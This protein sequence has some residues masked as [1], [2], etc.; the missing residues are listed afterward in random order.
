ML[1]ALTR[2]AALAAGRAERGAA[3]P[4]RHRARRR[5]AVRLILRGPS[6]ACDRQEGEQDHGARPRSDGRH[7]RRLASRLRTGHVRGLVP[8]RCPRQRGGAGGLGL[9][10]VPPRARDR[11][12]GLLRSTSNDGISGPRHPGEHESSAVVYAWMRLLACRSPIGDDRPCRGRGL[13]VSARISYVEPLAQSA[14]QLPFKL[15]TPGDGVPARV[16]RRHASAW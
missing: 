8:G 14:E 10:H 12:L 15:G 13:G 1:E 2:G 11:R 3:R 16:T 5:A 6:R 4:A 7:G 9:F